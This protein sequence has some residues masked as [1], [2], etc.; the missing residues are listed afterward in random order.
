MTWICYRGIE[1]SAR[2]QLFLLS[3]EVAILALFAVVALVKV[4][5]ASAAAARCT[6]SSSWFNPFDLAFSALIDGVLLGIFIY[7]GW[8]SGVAVNEESRELGRGA[9]QGG[10]V[11]TLLLVLIYLVVSTAAQ[12]YG[13]TN[14]SSDNSDDVLSVL[15]T[16]S[17]ARRG[18][19]C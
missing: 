15:G 9:G 3:A 5:A 1:L 14:F 2:T 10:R 12:A 7:W 6:S 17:S 13:G 11:S 8:D 4:Y 18:T 16:R 19:S